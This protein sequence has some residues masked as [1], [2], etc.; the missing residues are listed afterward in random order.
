MKESSSLYQPKWTEFTVQVQTKYHIY[1]LHYPERPKR[2]PV[3]TNIIMNAT[4]RR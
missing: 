4:Y 1:V 3:N 2:G